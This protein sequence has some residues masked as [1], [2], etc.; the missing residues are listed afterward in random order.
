M[1]GRAESWKKQSSIYV[2]GKYVK[3]TC[4]GDVL[5]L[6]VDIEAVCY[7][8]TCVDLVSE[9]TVN[10]WKMY[11]AIKLIVSQVRFS[12]PTGSRSSLYRIGRQNN[13]EARATERMR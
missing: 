8:A 12:G 6:R 9:L 4:F 13:A 5:S 11:K 3:E 1:K 10:E 2:W 7:P